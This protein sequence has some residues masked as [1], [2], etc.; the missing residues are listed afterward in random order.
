MIEIEADNSQCKKDIS[1][2]SVKL[3]RNIV[4]FTKEKNLTE[5]FKVFKA[6]Y[7]GVKAGQKKNKMLSFDLN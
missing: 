7:N 5:T 6:S 4:G 2:I 3:I 1:S